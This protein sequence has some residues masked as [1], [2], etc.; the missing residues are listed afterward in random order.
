MKMLRSIND[1]T[2]LNNGVLMPWLG[3][4]VWKAEGQDVVNAVKWAVEAG[5]RHID[6]AAVY[7]NEKEV[8]EG[9]KNCGVSRKDLFVTSKAFKM[10]YREVLDQMDQ[11]LIDLQ[12]DYVDLYLIHWPH[13]E[14]G[15]AYLD[16]W[17][18]MERIYKEGK[19]RAIGVANFYS[20]YLDRILAEGTVRP[21]VN[22]FECHP[23]YQMPELQ[24]YCREQGIQYQAYSPLGGGAIFGD[25]RIQKIADKY[26]KSIAQVVLRW[27]LQKGIIV[28][29]K[30][31]KQNRILSNMD[32][33][34]FELEEE[35]INTLN[36]FDI[37]T[38]ITCARPDQPWPE[39]LK[40]KEERMAKGARF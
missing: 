35:D 15:D 9:L 13:P 20:E 17:A 7:R 27:D 3:L 32:V 31:V 19:A 29:P 4:G 23:Y 40:E 28:I 37:N 1:V 33:F 5:Y 30:S 22:Q 18:A 36:S 26:G 11:T 6:T 8:G 21:A 10:S 34:D 25:E 14:L 12:T 2:K 38:K 16:V 24:K 39:F